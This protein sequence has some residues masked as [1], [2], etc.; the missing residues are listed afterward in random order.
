M[1]QLAV[2]FKHFY[3]CCE[4]IKCESLEVVDVPLSNYTV[5]HSMW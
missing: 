3:V 1:A 4:E 2:Q 5:T